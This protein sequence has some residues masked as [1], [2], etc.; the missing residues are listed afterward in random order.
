[1]NPLRKL[2]EGA[3]ALGA[4]ESAARLEARLDDLSILAARPLVGQVRSHGPYERIADAEF[5]VFSQFE[6][7]GIIQYLAHSTGASAEAPR[8]VEFGS[9]D[10]VES[11]TRFLLLNDNW[12]GTVLDSSA[13]NIERIRS[14][15]WFWKHELEALEAFVTRDNIDGLLEHHAPRGE[16][17]LLSI[18]VDGN[19]YWIWDAIESVEPR[20]V[21]VEYNSLF[22]PESAV[23]IP[24]EPL[25]DRTK[26]HFTNLY[27]GA[28]LAALGRVA[29]RK[30]YALVGCNSAGNNAYFVRRDVL[31]IPAL[32]PEQAFVRSRIRESRDEAGA[33]TYVAGPAR[34]ELIRELPVVDVDTGL[35]TTVDSAVR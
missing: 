33:L 16:L 1:M 26:A 31:H 22:G 11:N 23:T 13:A 2:V 6:D 20:I 17:G 12:S 19:D 7:D 34:F 3:V 27:W 5:K 10:Y 29:G 35:T 30:E 28:S 8:F 4:A 24:Y 32:T 14:T 21:V 25:F 18:D 9:S 15:P